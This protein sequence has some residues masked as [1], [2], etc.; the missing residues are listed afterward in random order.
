[1]RE[2]Q[3]GLVLARTLTP[4]RA[5]PNPTLFTSSRGFDG[6]LEFMP[7]ATKEMKPEIRRAAH[8]R[9]YAT[10]ILGSVQLFRTGSRLLRKKPQVAQPQCAKN[11]D[12]SSLISSGIAI[13]LR[14]AHH[15]R[16]FWTDVPTTYPITMTTTTSATYVQLLNNRRTKPARTA[17][18]T[19]PKTAVHSESDLSFGMVDGVGRRGATTIT[20]RRRQC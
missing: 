11:L 6:R 2:N 3:K 13:S 16:S 10:G 15:R 17:R 1:M 19:M 20:A 18:P 7:P 14:G 9:G 12:H 4:S 8:Q 5:K